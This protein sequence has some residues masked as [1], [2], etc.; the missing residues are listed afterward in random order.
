MLRL[1]MASVDS[2]ELD[3]IKKVFTTTVNFGLGVH[4]KEFEDELQKFIGEEVEVV[5]VNS[6][7]SALHLALESLNFP[8]GSEILVPSITFV[9]SYTAITQ[10]GL[11]PVSC[12]ITYPSCHIDVED[13]KR[14]VSSKTVAIMPVAYSGCDFDREKIYE[15]SNKHG[16]RVIEDDAH[17]FAS[18]NRDG[19]Y[20]GGSGDIV[21]F[22]FDGI[23]NITCGE[24]GAI[25]T[26]DK[27]FA[28][29]VR[30]RR[31]LGIEKDVE[32]RYKGQRAW[33]F[34]VAVQG[35]R[36]HMS[37]I[38]AAI[39]LAQL[40]KICFFKKQKFQLLTKYRDEIEHCKLSEYIT[41]T[42]EIH[43]SDCLHLF[44]CILAP[45]VNRPLLRR[46]LLEMGF[47]TGVHY[48]PNHRHTL[49]SSAYSL[50]VA[51]DMGERL[52]SFPFHPQVPLEAIPRMMTCIKEIIE[53][54]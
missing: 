10:A 53:E 49:F 5:C 20:F 39:G 12:D 36:Y 46:K 45:K 47:E 8:R 40:K 34:D 21:C 51:E 35:Y 4:V 16:L 38:N 17:A 50:P 23:K 24:G 7:T 9:A 54:K 15:I 2:A 11:V 31:S 42:Q 14:R 13:V 30:V 6:G 25:V 48:A 52:I 32:L 29:Q 1:S 41:H 18:I 22:S 28:H 26:K 3:E 44:S 37:N 43:E 27:A 33:D 19:V